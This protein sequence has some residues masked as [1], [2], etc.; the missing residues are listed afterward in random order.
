MK[1]WLK[2]IGSNGFVLVGA[3]FAVVAC[4]S[5]GDAAEKYPTSDSFCDAKAAEE[6]QVAARCG[7]TEVSCTTAREAA[8]STFASQSSGGSRQYRPGNADACITKTHDVYSQSAP[9]TPAI[10]AEI[11]SVCTKVFQ[12]TTKALG[13]CT[14]TIVCEGDLICDKKLCASKVIKNTGDLCGNP[15]EVCSEGSFCDT[16]SGGAALCKAKGTR[17]QVCNAET[18]PCSETLRCNN[19]CR[20]R[21]VAGESCGSNDDCA[22]S[23]PYCDPA[24][25]NKCGAGLT[26]A[27]GSGA[28]K[29][30]GG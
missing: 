6:C 27:A 2:G 1:S 17:D 22:P 12:G 24:N 16:F 11:D 21:F 13:A 18:A 4:S 10:Q 20:D 3:A 28:C 5:T 19:T 25:S 9:I 15:G 7:V 23:A 8:C 14:A 26:F 30:Y 29:A